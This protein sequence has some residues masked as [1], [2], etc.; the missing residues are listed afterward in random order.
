MFPSN[1]EKEMMAAVRKDII[2]KIRK[3][4]GELIDINY[5]LP[6]MI[7]FNMKVNKYDTTVEIELAEGVYDSKVI[8]MIERY[9]GKFDR[10]KIQL[11]GNIYKFDYNTNEYFERLN[12]IEGTPEG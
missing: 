4:Q 3:F 10:F 12:K 5:K 8:S 6:S 7:S 9:F 1:K 2:E 11:L